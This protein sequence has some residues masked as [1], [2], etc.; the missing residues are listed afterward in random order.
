MAMVPEFNPNGWRQSNVKLV[1]ISGTKKR[2]HMKYN[3]NWNKQEQKYQTCI[4]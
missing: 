2:E 1:D 4:T 3:I